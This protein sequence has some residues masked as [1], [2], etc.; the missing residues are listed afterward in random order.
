[1]QINNNELAKYA[2]H[3]GQTQQGA[4]SADKVKSS[5][6]QQTAGSSVTR[7]DAMQLSSRAQDIQ[8]IQE[9]LQNV[10]EVRE[11]L[12]K[13]SADA[14]AKGE[15]NLNGHDIAINLLLDPGHHAA[16]NPSTEPKSI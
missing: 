8:Q 9:I 7:S 1:M 6:A 12:I 11:N 16:T 4:N 15:L 13:E 14:M 10:P 3:I 2:L 5:N